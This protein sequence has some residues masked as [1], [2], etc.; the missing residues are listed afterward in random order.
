MSPAP[1][2]GGNPQKNKKSP[3]PVPGSQA[4]FHVLSHVNT[5]RESPQLWEVPQSRGIGT[6][7]GRRSKNFS[8]SQEIG[9]NSEKGN[10]GTEA[11]TG[12]LGVL[13]I[14]RWVSSPTEWHVRVSSRK[15]LGSSGVNGWGGEEGAG[16][17]GREWRG[18]SC[19]RRWVGGDMEGATGMTDIMAEGKGF[20]PRQILEPRMIP[21][22]SSGPQ[23]G[24]G[25]PLSQGSQSRSRWEGDSVWVTEPEQPPVNGSPRL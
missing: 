18:S 24:P 23:M 14:A 16:L 1:V 19:R 21:G 20:R 2:G 13:L 5:A 10:S 17:A 11:L 25:A 22:V 9:G 3:V 6:E 15:A 7:L 12:C 8:G 4:G